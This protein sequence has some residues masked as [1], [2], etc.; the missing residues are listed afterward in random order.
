MKWRIIL[1]I[2]CLLFLLLSMELEQCWSFGFYF[3]QLMWVISVSRFQSIKIFKNFSQYTARYKR[4]QIY[5]AGKLPFR[6]KNDLEVSFL[7]EGADSKWDIKP[8]QYCPRCMKQWCHYCHWPT[9][10]KHLVKLKVWQ[11]PANILGW[12]LVIKKPARFFPKLH[13]F[14]NHFKL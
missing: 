1:E 8:P 5:G 7:L 12:N 10:P 9:L 6:A 3:C 13:I 11:P 4:G 2:Y 14:Q